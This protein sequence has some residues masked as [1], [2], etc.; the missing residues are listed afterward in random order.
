[1]HVIF[2]LFY[3]IKVTLKSH[4]CV[5][6]TLKFCHYVRTVVMDVMTFPENL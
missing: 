5:K 1:M 6:K 3:D 4:F 2:Y